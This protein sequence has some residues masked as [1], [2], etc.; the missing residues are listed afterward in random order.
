MGWS[1]RTMWMAST[2]D[3]RTW[4]DEASRP[5][6]RHRM[7]SI[8]RFSPSGST[9]QNMERI[10]PHAD[11]AADRTCGNSSLKALCRREICSAMYPIA[12][13]FLSASGSR[14]GNTSPSMTMERARTPG[15][16]DRAYLKS[17]GR[18]SLFSHASICS[19]LGTACKGDKR[20]RRFSCSPRSFTRKA[21][22][23]SSV[24]SRTSASC[25]PALE[26]VPSPWYSSLYRSS[27]LSSSTSGWWS[28]ALG[29][30]AL[31]VLVRTSP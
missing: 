31:R 26:F 6:P 29:G 9:S 2:A 10:R 24:S 3:A 22:S 4:L 21:N 27:S 30:I 25:A 1:L 19:G 12:A 11:A 5:R 28:P 8:S 20:L 18:Y 17:S 7:R 14:R 15:F 23:S 16:R 13:D